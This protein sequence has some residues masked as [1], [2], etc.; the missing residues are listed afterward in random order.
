MVLLCI[1]LIIAAPTALLAHALLRRSAP[2]AGERLTLS[3]PAIT[4]W[5]S[6]R[7]ELRFT[8]LRL[9]DSAG[10]E[11]SLGP[12]APVPELGVRASVNSILPNGG[13]EVTWQTAAA[14]G[15]VSRGRYH[16]TVITAPAASA[17]APSAAA[18]TRQ[19]PRRPADSVA[20]QRD[21]AQA[22][23]TASSIRGQ[24][25]LR[26]VEFVG[27]LTIA[28]SLVFRLIVLR[29]LASRGV[30]IDAAEGTRRLAQATVVLVAV[31]L[32]VRLYDE[33]L[34]L[35]GAESAR[36]PQALEALVL[37]TSWGMGWL[38][39]AI[40]VAVVTSGLA[41][42]RRASTAGWSIATAGAAL[43]V[44]YPA[45]TGHAIAVS[46]YEVAAVIDDSLHLAA[47][48]AWLGTLLV[49][50]LV[51][52]PAVLRL[53]EPLR[54]P[55]VLAL[56]R[57]FNPVALA[58]AAVVV[59]TGIISASFHLPHVAHLWTS[60]YGRILLV[61]I[62][63][64]LFILVLG[65][66]NWRRVTPALDRPESSRRIRRS[67]SVELLFTAVLLAV[68]AILSSTATPDAG[69]TS[70]PSSSASTITP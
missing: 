45:L 16:F 35:N 52:I 68:T 62:G 67:A 54:G 64:F 13:Y 48:A 55:T 23:E 61:K 70:A 34:L 33:S 41:L 18:G 57:A 44:I 49:V 47:A 63:C 14:D 58:G 42:V 2:A 6:E 37:S 46:G 28:G 9:T 39:G 32:L 21:T 27:L 5:F 8:R 12:L 59:L 11:T 36:D 51:A 26:W 53:E 56:I 19:V 4:L 25:V 7:P 31:S 3:P 22:V 20:A 38:I 65:A 10:V 1:L 40:G 43:L 24:V 69:A 29:G 60:T 66:Y 17:P 15:H 30:R 50:V